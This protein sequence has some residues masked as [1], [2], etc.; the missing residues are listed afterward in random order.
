MLLILLYFSPCT[1][2]YTYLLYFVEVASD[3]TAFCH[4]TGCPLFLYVCVACK[5]ERNH[6]KLHV[7][8]KIENYIFLLMCFL[9]TTMCFDVLH[10]TALQSLSSD[11]SVVC[12]NIILYMNLNVV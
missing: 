8:G 4:I 6:V 9:I 3:S 2:T 10:N 7:S 5:G 11:S 12:Y 1:H